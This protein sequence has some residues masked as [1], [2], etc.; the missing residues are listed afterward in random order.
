MPLGLRST[1][2]QAPA[3]RL[4]MAPLQAPPG[5]ATSPCPPHAVPSAPRQVP[6]K[7]RQACLPTVLWTALRP[8]LAPVLVLGSLSRSGR[9]S[10]RG[11]EGAREQGA[12]VLRPEPWWGQCSVQR[13]ENLRGEVRLTRT[14]LKEVALQLLVTPGPC[15]S[16]PPL[17]TPF[18]VTAERPHPTRRARLTR[19]A[20]GGGSPGRAQ[21]VRVSLRHSPQGLRNKL[22]LSR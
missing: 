9:F 11:L 3:L 14:Q 6:R 10:T 17:Q 4:C 20:E 18:S 7:R 8:G 2:H 1:A 22:F 12:T 21:A 5:A 19:M 13:L 15:R 16:R